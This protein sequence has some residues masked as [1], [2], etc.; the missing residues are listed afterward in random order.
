MAICLVS[1][2]LLYNFSSFLEQYFIHAP[3]H[4]NWYRNEGFGEM[5]KTVKNSTNSDWFWG[6]LKFDGYD[7]KTIIYTDILNKTSEVGDILNLFSQI[8]SRCIV[9]FED[10]DNYFDKRYKL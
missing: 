1:T 9:L 7:L 3:I 8:S 10:F 6:V 2:L 4:R 5:V